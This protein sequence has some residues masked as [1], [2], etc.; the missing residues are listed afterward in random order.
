LKGLDKWNRCLR[1][2][3]EMAVGL[4]NCENYLLNEE[5]HEYYEMMRIC[6]EL[7]RKLHMFSANVKLES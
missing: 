7:V 6:P 2:S 5:S 4:D 3:M 1:I